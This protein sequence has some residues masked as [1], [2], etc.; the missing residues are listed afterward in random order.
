MFEDF[1]MTQPGSD[2][3]RVLAR[4]LGDMWSRVSRQHLSSGQGCA[5]GF[6]GGLLLQGS[7]FELDIVEFLIDAARQAGHG[8][9]LAFIDMVAKRGP[10]SYNLPALLEALGGGEHPATPDRAQVAFALERLRATLSAMDEAHG[11]G[12]FACD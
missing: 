8:E 10:D 3:R 1:A 12:R 11:R 7:A 4:E 2:S 5:C 6:G 9:L